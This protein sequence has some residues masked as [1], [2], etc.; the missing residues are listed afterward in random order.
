MNFVLAIVLGV[1]IGIVLGAFATE[2]GWWLHYHGEE[3]L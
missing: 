1:A 3:D 2:V